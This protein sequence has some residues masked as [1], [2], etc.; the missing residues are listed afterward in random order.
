MEDD[1]FIPPEPPART[2]YGK[3]ALVNLNLLITRNNHFQIGI[4]GTKL[5]S[6]EIHGTLSCL[7]HQLSHAFL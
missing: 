5:P 6:I 7:H 2:D 1:D 3:K 4:S